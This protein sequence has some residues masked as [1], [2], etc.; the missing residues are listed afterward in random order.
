MKAVHSPR[1]LAGIYKGQELRFKYRTAPSPTQAIVRKS[2]FDRLAGRLQ[3]TR[4]LDGFA[5]SGAIGVEALS[6]GAGEVVFIER[7]VQLARSLQ[8]NLTR[9]H[10]LA[11]PDGQTTVLT[12][13]F[14]RRSRQLSSSQF[15]IIFLDPPYAQLN[16]LTEYK[17][18]LKQLQT[19]KLLCPTGLLIIERLQQLASGHKNATFENF[20]QFLATQELQVL[21]TRR[22]G[23]TILEFYENL[24]KKT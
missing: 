1:I 12:G 4:I 5:G 20:Q 15:D 21:Q 9:L 8:N 3:H 2:L 16:T 14:Y 23:K 17:R 7:D 24:H 13:D 11:V 6:R 19:M 18:L 10:A 22:F